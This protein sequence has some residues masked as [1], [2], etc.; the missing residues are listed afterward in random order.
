MEREVRRADDARRGDVRADRTGSIRHVRTG[1]DRLRSAC[2]RSHP[3]NCRSERAHAEAPASSSWTVAAV[4]PEAVES[5]VR[6][7]GEDVRN[8]VRAAREGGAC[9]L[10]PECGE[11]AIGRA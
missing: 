7:D 8:R 5:A 4:R 2:P 10:T 3:E 1:V 6:D 11:R 9:R